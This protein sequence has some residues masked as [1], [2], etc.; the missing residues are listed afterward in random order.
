MYDVDCSTCL[1]IYIRKNMEEFRFVN[2]AD[3]ACKDGC[4]MIFS[5]ICLIILE[6]RTYDKRCN[7]HLKVK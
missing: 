5:V 4:I 3:E 2:K 7:K 1:Y 6:L